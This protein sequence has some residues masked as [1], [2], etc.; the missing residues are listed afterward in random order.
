V[1]RDDPPGWMDEEELPLEVEDRNVVRRLERGQDAVLRAHRDLHPEPKDLVRLVEGDHE[2]GDLSEGE[3]R[4]GQE[5][6]PK[7]LTTLDAPDK[8]SEERRVGKEGRCQWG[9]G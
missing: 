9:R 1:C 6:Q 8:R 7:Q 2:R 4:A 5:A 3:E